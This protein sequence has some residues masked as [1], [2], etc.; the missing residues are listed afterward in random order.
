MNFC[1]GHSSKCHL[2]VA[3]QD[4]VQAQTPPTVEA[5]A[6]KQQQHEN[7]K[8]T[9]PDGLTFTAPEALLEPF[10]AN[11]LRIF[12]RLLIWFA[13]MTNVMFHSGRF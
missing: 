4:E 9:E 13:C 6:E 3:F 1:C 2:I 5:N 10:P 12:V 8:A 7:K 11:P